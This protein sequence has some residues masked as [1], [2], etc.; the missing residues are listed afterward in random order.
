MAETGP[1][2]RGCNPIVGTA[3][4]TDAFSAMA[5]RHPDVKID[6]YDLR[7]GGK[8]RRRDAPGQSV[9]PAAGRAGGPAT[10]PARSYRSEEHT[11][12][13]QSH[14]NLLFPLLLEKKKT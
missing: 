6:A 13:L 4:S 1:G 9:R 2:F 10:F 11:S 5:T 7:Q 12:E 8:V 3:L 14:F